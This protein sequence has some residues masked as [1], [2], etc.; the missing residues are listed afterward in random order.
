M[1][2]AADFAMVLS[3]RKLAAAC[4][5]GDI[6]AMRTQA[7][8]MLAAHPRVDFVR[9]AAGAALLF[10]GD[11]AAALPLLPK[12]AHGHRARAYLALA[13]YEDARREVKAARAAGEDV[14]NLS[15]DVEHAA[16]AAGL[17]N[18]IELRTEADGAEWAGWIR[19]TER[20]AAGQ[21]E[22]GWRD[23]VAVMDSYPTT[24][25]G[26][27]AL[28]RLGKAPCPRWDGERVGR[29]L[30]VANGGI[31]D[32]LQYGRAI[33]DARERCAHLS[34]AVNPSLH[35]I[36]ART[37]AIDALLTPTQ[38][39]AALQAADAYVPVAFAGFVL[40]GA[41]RDHGNGPWR[42]EPLPG[43]VPDLGPGAH[44]GLCWGASASQGRIRSI[45]F[46]ALEPL[47]DVSGVTFHSLQKGI[48]ANDAG[49]WVR[50]HELASWEH[51]TSLI[52]ALDVVVSVDTAVAHLAGNVGVPVH[53]LLGEFQDWRWGMGDRTPWY[54]TTT[55]YRG[56]VPEA[57]AAI[58]AKL[59]GIV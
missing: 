49:P 13:R 25:V 48:D 47:R 45:P 12:T 14:T 10:S 34:V 35:P 58:R 21:A 20:I 9:E 24:K 38:L 3:L 37:L 41:G 42:I 40:H 5:A 55:L 54:S 23:L 1:L 43:T 29:L 39:P 53:M 46:A 28:Q 16:N 51:T 11:A 59:G 31:G 19:A 32:A 36:M 30:V 22:E 6:S 4:T 17:P 56:A 27:K 50:R 15:L 26:A 18:S 7:N 52:A 33:R 57:V 44:V 2:G 8:A